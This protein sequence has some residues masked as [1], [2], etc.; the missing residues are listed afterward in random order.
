MWTVR[1]VKEPYCLQVVIIPTNQT[2]CFKL[3]PIELTHYF[4][5]WTLL[6]QPIVSNCVP[7]KPGPLFQ[8][9]S[10]T[11]HIHCFNLWLILMIHIVSSFGPYNAGPLFQVVAPTNQVKIAH[12]WQIYFAEKYSFIFRNYM[13]LVT[14]ISRPQNDPIPSLTA[15]LSQ[16]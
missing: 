1:L 9:V 11:Q 13:Y 6:N 10:F 2:H 7:E 12:A 15:K 3:T 14:N 8:N 4:K 5:F 16:L